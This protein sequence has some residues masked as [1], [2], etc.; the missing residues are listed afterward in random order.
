MFADVEERR[1]LESLLHPL[2]HAARVE[3]I[4]R[5]S[6]DGA[7]AVIVD[8]PLL[9]EAGVDQECDA[10]VFVEASREVRARRV[11]E[12]RGWDSDEL[13]RRESTQMP[14]EEKRRERICDR[15]RGGLM[16]FGLRL[17]V[18][19]RGGVVGKGWG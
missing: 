9:F 19:W 7:R 13:A 16:R 15:E 17:S 10:V 14:I 11:K 5:A 8:A 4:R 3:V 12:S 18:C 6:A 1:R 2:V